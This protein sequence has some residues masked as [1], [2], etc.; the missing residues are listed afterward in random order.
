MVRSTS[1][2]AVRSLRARSSLSRNASSSAPSFFVSAVSRPSVL[3]CCERFNIRI[4]CFASARSAS[5]SCHVSFHLDVSPAK[6]ATRSSAARSC[7]CSASLC[8][9][10]SSSCSSACSARRRHVSSSRDVSPRF[11]S[12][13][14][15]SSTSK[16]LASRASWR[17]ASASRCAMDMA[18][19]AAV[20]A[21]RASTMASDSSSKRSSSFEDV[22]AASFSAWACE[23]RRRRQSS[24]MPWRL[25]NSS[26]RDCMRR[27]C[28]SNRTRRSSLSLS[29]PATCSSTMSM[30]SL[31]SARCVASAL[32][33]S[34]TVAVRD[35]LMAP[36]PAADVASRPPAATAMSR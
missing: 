4:S 9:E 26:L 2:S 14:A 27:S 24:M 28:S 18:S 32:S 12:A 29:S 19:S 16:L 21:R 11:L 1:A 25:A 22:M 17:A 10:A 31:C 15:R 8:S 7:A 20:R 34:D 13:A 35:M 6:S 33:K 23:A 30:R 36:S 5:I 3:S